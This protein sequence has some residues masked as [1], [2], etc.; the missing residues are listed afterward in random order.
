MSIAIHIDSLVVE[1][2]SSHPHL[3]GRIQRAMERELHRLLRDGPP[4][5]FSQGGSLPAITAPQLRVAAQAPPAE[6]GREIARSLHGMLTGS[7]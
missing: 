4:I 2:V 7:L 1:G 3:A 5:S 6:I